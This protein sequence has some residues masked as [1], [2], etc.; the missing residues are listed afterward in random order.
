MTFPQSQS[1]CANARIRPQPRD[2]GFADL[3]DALGRLVQHLWSPE[4]RKMGVY[5]LPVTLD[6]TVLA[7][8]Y[9]LVFTKN[10]ER[11]YLSVVKQ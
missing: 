3:Y 4:T 1:R 6:A 9:F 7:G 11:R 5:K 2:D 8:V 10:G